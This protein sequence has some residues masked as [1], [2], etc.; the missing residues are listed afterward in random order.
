MSFCNSLCHAGGSIL[1]I[2]YQVFE[3]MARVWLLLNNTPAEGLS[4]YA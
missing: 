4:S 3:T 1:V 2:A